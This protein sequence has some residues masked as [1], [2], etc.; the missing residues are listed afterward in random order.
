MGNRNTGWNWG[1]RRSLARKHKAQDQLMP[2]RENMKHRPYV[3]LTAMA[4]LSFIAMY[5][6]MYAMVNSFANVFNN[7]NQVY[8]AGLMAAPMVVSSSS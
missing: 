5:V 3:R 2:G 8:M 6:L 4:I 7:I 1:I